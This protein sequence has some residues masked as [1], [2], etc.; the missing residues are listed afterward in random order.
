MT[1]IE[2]I[3]T[4]Y[5]RSWIKKDISIMRTHFSPYVVYTECYGPVYQNRRQCLQWFR[6]WNLRGTVL[7]WDIKNSFVLGQTVIVEWYFECDYEGNIDGFDGI[8]IVEFDDNDQIVSV[9]EFQSKTEHEY[10]YED[11]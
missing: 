10:P 8:S 2:N 11:M 3:V 1:N 6:E 7:K 9:K 4:E 5:L